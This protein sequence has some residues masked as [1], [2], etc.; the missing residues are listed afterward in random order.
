M[1]SAQI[2][3]VSDR[4]VLLVREVTSGRPC[5]VEI[6]AREGRAIVLAC[7]YP[8]D[9][10]VYAALLGRLGVRPRWRTDATEPG[11]VIAA[12][13]DPESGAELVHL[14][15]VAPYPLT[16]TLRRDDR[17]GMPEPLTVPAR[18]AELLRVARV[19]ADETR[20]AVRIIT[21]GAGVE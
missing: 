1:S 6:G 15:N 19:G 18:G 17:E 3:D 13:M 14:I 16:V 2:I 5:A 12:M 20:T 21:R 4:A 8:A 9:L 11:L 10:A 7:D